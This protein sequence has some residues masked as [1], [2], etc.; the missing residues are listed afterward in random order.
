MKS[1]LRAKS[2]GVFPRPLRAW[3]WSHR[4][5]FIVPIFLLLF[6][7]LPLIEIYFMIEVGSEI[8][9]LSTIGLTL[10]TA[11]I[12]TWLVRL[13]GFGVLARV[14]EL[15]ERGEVPALELMDGALILIAGLFLL[16]PGFLTDALG[17][18]L[19]IP[20]VRRWLIHHYV[21]IVPAHSTRPE[22]KRGEPRLIEGRFRR[23]D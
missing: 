22:E 2:F 10:L 4:E 20:P 5:A 16:L 9:A 13:Q 6:I 12:G 7:G 18:L 11:V 14:R 17:F 1:R 15:M 3:A 23:D 8:G 19:L 21:R